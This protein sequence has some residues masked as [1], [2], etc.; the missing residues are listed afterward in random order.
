MEEAR[1]CGV[2]WEDDYKT[3]VLLGTKI[4]IVMSSIKIMHD[5]YDEAKEKFGI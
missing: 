4:E 1:I 2:I 5:K 3:D